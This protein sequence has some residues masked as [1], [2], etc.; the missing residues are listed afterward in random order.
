MNTSDLV[1]EAMKKAE[2]IFHMNR[3]TRWILQ[4]IVL[5]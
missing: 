4:K 2:R 3:L 5:L 1:K